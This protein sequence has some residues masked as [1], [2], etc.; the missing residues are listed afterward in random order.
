MIKS[1]FHLNSTIFSV[2]IFRHSISR[3]NGIASNSITQNSFQFWV[4]CRN[5]KAHF[6]DR[7][8]RNSYLLAKDIHKTYLKHYNSRSIKDYVAKIERNTIKEKLKNPDDLL[9]LLDRQNQL[10]S[11]F[12]PIQEKIAQIL[13]HYLPNILPENYSKRTND[14][15]GKLKPA[16]VRLLAEKSPHDF[17]NLL[18][19]KLELILPEQS[20][21]KKPC[22]FSLLTN[23]KNLQYHKKLSPTISTQENIDPQEILDYHCKRVW[24]EEDFF[25]NKVRFSCTH[26]TSEESWI[27]WPSYKNADQKSL[28]DSALTS[29]CSSVF[30]Y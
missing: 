20:I 25:I 7:P 19:R 29:S 10:K 14:A 4:A 12:D 1:P 9:L 22:H 21:I 26:K 11:I 15:G 17:A 13:S 24:P 28:E 18:I 30:G 5:F 8:W 16:H 3:R 2:N 27:L 6:H 23:V